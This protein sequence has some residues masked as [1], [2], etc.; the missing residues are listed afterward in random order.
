LGREDDV[1]AKARA[2]DEGR[3]CLERLLDLRG[4]EHGPRAHDQAF[5]RRHGADRLDGCSRTERDLGDRQ[6]A[7]DEGPAQ[8]LGVLG[9]VQDDHR[10]D[11]SG[12]H[13]V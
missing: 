9:I 12:E 2:D 1:S 3:A 11:P 7:G 10:H 4:I 5:D 8:R 13:L 6:A